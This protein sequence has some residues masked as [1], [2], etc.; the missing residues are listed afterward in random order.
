MRG[1]EVGRQGGRGKWIASIDLPSNVRFSSVFVFF[2]QL[3]R[4]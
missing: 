4:L 2:S 1:R 3:R